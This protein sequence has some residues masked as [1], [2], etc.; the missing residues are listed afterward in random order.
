MTDFDKQLGIYHKMVQSSI[1]GFL[2][3]ESDSP[4]TL[5]EAMA[6]SLLGMGKRVRAILLLAFYEF[7]GGKDTEKAMPF[8]AALEMIHAYS[9]IHDDLP[10]MDNDDMRRGK[11]SNHIVFGEANALL[12]G[13][14]LLT[15]AFETMVTTENIAAFGSEK[16][17][18]ALKVLANA[19]GATGMIAGQIMDLENEGVEVSAEELITTD[20]KKTG[21]LICAAAEMGCILAGANESLFTAANE[22][23]AKMGL[24]FQ[25]VDDILDKIG[26]EAL[27]GKPIGSDEEQEKSTYVT[28]YGL[29]KAQETA[30]QLTKEAVAAIEPLNSD[31]TFLR[32]LVE[33]LCNRTY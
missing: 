15:L 23:A 13:D 29:E 25:I 11:S 5:R 20:E 27:L 21:A 12:A 16:V 19:A 33:F 32:A 8:A 17:L 22:Y 2:P 6:Y 9:L 7:C 24:A 3:E 4:R 26:D 1:A 10:C 31:S 14:A 30:K 28:V 18:S